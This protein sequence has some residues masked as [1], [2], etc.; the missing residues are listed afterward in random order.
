MNKI[1]AQLN[2]HQILN[3]YLKEGQNVMKINDEENNENS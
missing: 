2:K 3:D 1:Q